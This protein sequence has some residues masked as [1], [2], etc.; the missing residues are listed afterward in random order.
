MITLYE[1][2]YAITYIYGTYIVY[3]LLNVFFDD[4]RTSKTIEISSYIGYYFIN[5]ALFFMF[6]IPIVLMISNILLFFLLTL[7][8]NS[9]FKRRIIFSFL[10]YMILM[11]AEVILTIMTGYFDI[12]VFKNSEYSSILGLV[13]VR[14]IS[15]L[16]VLAISNYKNV[17]KEI[18]ISTFSWINSI[19]V[20]F[21]SL[22]FFLVFIDKGNLEQINIMLLVFWVLTINFMLI[23]L[24][25]NLYREFAV[26]SKKLILEQQNKSYKKQLDLM[27]QSVKNT[28]ILNHDIKNH[29]ITLRNLHIDGKI[30]SI[31][32]YLDDIMDYVDSN[33][34][35]S[36]SGNNAVDSILNFKLQEII[37]MGEE[38]EIEVNI[39]KKTNIS[40]YDITVILGNLIDN[41]ITALKGYEDRKKLSI[42]IKYIKSNIIITIINSFNGKLKYKNG[43]LQTTK[44]DVKNHG[45]GLA[46]V[47]EVVNKN[48]GH[49]DIKYDDKN[50]RVTV[51]L[52]IAKK[53]DL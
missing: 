43:K 15:L 8:Y 30:E 25:E 52:P 27:E 50:F 21:G 19:I 12:P 26:K 18:P 29:V 22:Y 4:L 28:Q 32:E 5:L 47:E 33:K 41:S 9:S 38:V 48:D 37:D 42:K 17:K 24:Y 16:V 53:M 46:S 39:P 36:N 2:V 31:G 1:A 34:K 44:V 7:N 11:S 49:L 40:D 13:L 6:R 45:L 35:F 3:K 51:I 14:I 23:E 10:S 20:S